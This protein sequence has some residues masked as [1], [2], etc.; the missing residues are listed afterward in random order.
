MRASPS[1]DSISAE[2]QP[3]NGDGWA[4][5]QHEVCGKQRRAHQAGDARRAVDDDMIE[6][7]GQLRGLA[8][9]RV[10]RQSDDAENALVDPRVRA[11]A[12]NRA[13]SLGGSASIRETR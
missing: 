6:I 9:Q 13:Q 11:A 7:A 12:T 5:D 2:A 3:S 4:G 10:A 1:S 8:V